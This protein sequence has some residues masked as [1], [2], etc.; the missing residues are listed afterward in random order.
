[1]ADPTPLKPPLRERKHAATRD[2][3]H[4]VA[5]GLFLARG[6][7]RVSV[8]EIADAA[9]VAPRTFFRYFPV[10]EDAALALNDDMM[11]VLREAL[12]AVDQ[13]L[14]PLVQVRDALAESLNFMHATSA[15]GLAEL[16][17]REPAIAARLEHHNLR[18]EEIIADHLEALAGGGPARRLR[19]RLFAAAAA[20][21]LMHVR[22]ERIAAHSLPEDYAA[23][24]FDFVSA[25]QPAWDATMASETEGP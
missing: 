12:L 13:A 16:L 7:S 25:L 15:P 11:R 20:A 21:A 10:K 3:I 14:P 6:F 2:H 4:R 5:L 17:A 24:A 18:Y 8:E 23:I 9:N 22:R 19:A 1:M